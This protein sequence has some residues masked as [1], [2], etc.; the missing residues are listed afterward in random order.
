MGKK[1]AK[2]KVYSYQ[3]P[4]RSFFDPEHGALG[5]V[6]EFRKGSIVVGN[7]WGFNTTVPFKRKD[8]LFCDW[9]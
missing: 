5:Y 4:T 3:G 6:A 1:K 9:L 7:I 8:W 2:Y